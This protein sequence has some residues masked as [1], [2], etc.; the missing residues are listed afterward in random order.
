M[1]IAIV[2]EVFLPKIDGVVNRTMNL[3]R[4]L[5]EFGDEVL[6]IC[7]E[8]KGCIGCPVPVVEVPSFSFALYPEYRVALPGAEVV[9]ALQNFAPDVIHYVNPFLRFFA[10]SCG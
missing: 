10:Y 9:A 6:V 7:P 8:A 1:R 4:Q 2:A 5:I 3:I